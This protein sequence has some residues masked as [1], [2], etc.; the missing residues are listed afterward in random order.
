MGTKVSAA[1]T[2]GPNRASKEFMCIMLHKQVQR[3]YG[4]LFLMAKRHSRLDVLCAASS[5]AVST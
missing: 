4:N 3:V 5:C 1:V 2:N